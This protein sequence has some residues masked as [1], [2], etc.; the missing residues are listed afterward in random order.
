MF[1]CSNTTVFLFL[2]NRKLFMEN[3]ENI[4]FEIENLIGELQKYNDA[5]KNGDREE[6]ERLLSE[7]TKIKESIG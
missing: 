5:I 2:Q 4:T 1:V 6:L 7:G 3:S